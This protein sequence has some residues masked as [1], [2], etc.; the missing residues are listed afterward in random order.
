MRSLVPRCSSAAH[1]SY[2]TRSPIR[3]LVRRGLRLNLYQPMLTPYHHYRWCRPSPGAKLILMLQSGKIST[4]LMEI[5]SVNSPSSLVLAVVVVG[6]VVVVGI[7]VVVVVILVPNYIYIT[8][9]YLLFFIIQQEVNK[10][11]EMTWRFK[12]WP[13]GK[14]T[15]CL[16]HTL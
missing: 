1:Q 16:P 2:T 14:P 8:L 10:C 7:V 3:M 9:I 15:P 12:S 13:K 4:T 5:S 6:V 11:L